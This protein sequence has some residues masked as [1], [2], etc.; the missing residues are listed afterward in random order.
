MGLA[1][2]VKRIE[3]SPP[4]TVVEPVPVQ[5]LVQVN[6]PKGV[7][8]SI[9]SFVKGSPVVPVQPGKY[10][11][12]ILNKLTYIRDVNK[13]HAFFTDIQLQYIADVAS[14]SD[15]DSLTRK[16]NFPS[17]ELTIEFS[18]L[19]LYDVVI[20]ADDSGS[21]TFD[22]ERT[23]DLQ[24]IITQ[25]AEIATC[26]DKDG[27]T[28]RTFKDTLS[29]DN[30]TNVVKVQTEVNKMNYNGGTPMGNALRSYVLDPLVFKPASKQTLQKP[31][32]VIV[33]TDG[34]PDN[35]YDVRNAVLNAKSTL[36]N[37]KYGPK[38]VAFQFAQVGR[39]RQAQA[40]LGEIDTDA[41][42]GDM[43]DATSYFEHEQDEYSRKGID[44][45]PYLW[46]LKLIMGSIDPKY[47]S[48]DEM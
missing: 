15:L 7:I 45:T 36:S 37:T 19:A 3:S 33:V 42:I 39:D 26:F 20:L 30:L 32:L 6:E 21:M 41:D 16:L 40:W 29:A 18:A 8:A 22:K 17:V 24:F 35:K 28:L 48:E 4:I 46:I 2:V 14:Q 5:A 11:D 13:L 34:A 1:D 31:V 23:D 25:V 9:T 43:I 10:R 47:D 38:A 27:I 12:A 44:L